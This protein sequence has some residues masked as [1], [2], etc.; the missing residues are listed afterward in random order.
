M[1]VAG[2]WEVTK[3]SRNNFL[4]DQRQISRFYAPLGKFARSLSSLSKMASTPIHPISAVSASASTH[5][6]GSFMQH[7]AG[8][9]RTQNFGRSSF[10]VAVY[11]NR[12]CSHFSSSMVQTDRPSNAVNA[13][14]GTHI[15]SRKE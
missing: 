13:S 11:F 8:R 7:M 14:A 6:S 10:V 1:G 3:N 12:H 9:V 15:G 4:T 2:L 5:P